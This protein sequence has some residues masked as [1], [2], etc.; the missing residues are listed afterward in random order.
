MTTYHITMS[1][2]LRCDIEARNA[3]DALQMALEENL[4]LKVS[5]VFS[6][7]EEKRFGRIDYKIPHHK[8][9]VG[10]TPRTKAKDQ[11][12]GRN[13][14]HVQR[15]GDERRKTMTTTE[16]IEALKHESQ[17][18]TTRHEMLGIMGHNGAQEEVRMAALLKSTANTIQDQQ[19]MIDDLEAY[20]GKAK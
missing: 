12:Q 20:Q 18:I 17:A 1:S 13:G 10:F 19:A 11:G 8:A 3:S 4:G 15:S 2:G 5:A 7:R 14:P 6:G 16:L 9:L